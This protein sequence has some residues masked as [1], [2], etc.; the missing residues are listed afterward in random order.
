MYYRS[1]PRTFSYTKWLTILATVLL[2]LCSLSTFA[3]EQEFDLDSEAA[4]PP[5]HK[6]LS[7]AKFSLMG[8]VDLTSET[9][10]PQEP[11]DNSTHE[12][13]N[14]HFFLFLKVK[15]SEKTSFMGEFASQEFFQVDY[16]LENLAT[17]QFGKL[18][19]P[20]GDTR[21]FHHYYGGVNNKMFP[22]IWASTGANVAWKFSKLE[23]D[24]YWVN[25]FNAATVNTTPTLPS[26][27]N[28]RQ[29]GGLRL[30]APLMT[31]VTGIFSVYAGEYWPG[32]TALLSGLDI[33]SEY[34]PFGLSALKNLRFAFGLANATFAEA[35]G[36]QFDIRG[37]FIEFITNLIGSGE[38]HLRYGTYTDN[39]N[40]LTIDSE[41]D[42]HAFALGYR[43][44]IDV[45]RLLV[46]H[47]WNFE[48]VNETD[49]DVFR[50]MASLD[51]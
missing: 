15:A 7:A 3:Q 8:R 16:T 46:E 6:T 28:E 17:I 32:R 23:V 29:A 13:N 51:F 31:N 41:N 39:N 36:G 5:A 20:F 21:R 43:M 9:T 25:T 34:K 48:A 14:K 11:S 33:Y 30:T 37:D 22:L 42:T 18:I 10:D 44:N 38:T 45:I 27:T 47:E 26:S 2:V 12:L 24:T 4:T 49:N 40:L 19:V 50:I 1:Y 35:P